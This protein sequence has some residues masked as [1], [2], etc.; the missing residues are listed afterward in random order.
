VV[1]ISPKDNIK[2]H[3]LAKTFPRIGAVS[4][5]ISKAI[6]LSGTKGLGVF[7][8]RCE[9]LQVAMNIAD[10]GPHLQQT[11]STRD[12]RNDPLM[13]PDDCIGAGTNI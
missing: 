6:K 10:D 5:S 9:R 7:Q 4:N 12:S 2:R 8:N 3:H 11:S 13:L 1:V